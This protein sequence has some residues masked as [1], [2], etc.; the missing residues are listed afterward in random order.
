MGQGVVKREG[1]VFIRNWHF[2]REQ[3][4]VG[5]SQNLDHFLGR[6]RAKLARTAVSMWAD[7]RNW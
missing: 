1:V 6:G 2:S 5:N 7:S 3:N 4:G